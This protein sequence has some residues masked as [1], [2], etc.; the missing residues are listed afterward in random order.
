VNVFDAGWR[1]LRRIWRRDPGRDIDA[2]LRFHFEERIADLVDGGADPDHARAEAGREFGDVA[3]VRKQLV[4]IDGQIAE[5]T[6]RREWWEGVRDEMRYVLRSL[7]RSPGFVAAVT[8]TLA[9]GLGANVAIFSLLDRL[10]LRAQPGIVQPA[11]I[12]RI[13]QYRPP[14][15]GDHPPVSSARPREDVLGIFPYPVY[16]EMRAAIPATVAVTGYAT[17][18][19]AY[20]VGDQAPQIVVTYVLSDYF[21]LLGA[22]PV[23][24]RFFAPEELRI[25][26]PLALVVISER[27]WRSQFGASPAAI[28]QSVEIDGHRHQ[29]IGVAA[30][31]FHGPDNDA[32]DLWVPMNTVMGFET[33]RWKWY[34]EAHTFNTRLLFRAATR[35]QVA[36][37]THDAEMV[38]RH[39]SVLADSLAEARISGLVQSVIPGND[40]SSVDIATRL[41]GVS[42]I[43]LLIACANVGNLLLTRGM[44]RR[45]EIAVRL[46]LGVSRA[47]LVRL[48][49]LEGLALAL[50]GAAI[51]IAV[52]IWGASAL[53]HLLLPGTQWSDG[54]IDSRVIVFTLVLAIVTG[55]AAS[56]FPALQASNPDLVVALKAGA[57]EGI[58]QRSRLRTGLL[59]AQTA[60]SVVLLAGAG[61]FLRSLGSVETVHTGYDG[62]HLIFADVSWNHELSNH[63]AD[64]TAR[65]PDYLAQLRRLPGVETVGY[66]NIAPFRG[67]QFKDFYLP[68]RDS[69]PRVPL[70]TTTPVSADYFRAAGIRVLG[71]R[72]FLASDGPGTPLVIVVSQTFARRFWPG[73]NAVGQCVIIDKRDG[74]CREVI[75]IVSD[76]HMHDIVEDETPLQMYLPKA[77]EDD[78]NS[79]VVIVRA[80]P[81]AI[82]GLIPLIR[83]TTIATYGDWA[84]PRVHAMREYLDAQLR[85]WRLG[86]ILFSVAGF[87]AL[88][89]SLVGI[90]STI[91]YTF[92]QRTHEIGV[93]V[94]LG[95]RAMNVVRLVV[96]DGVR[97]VL[98]GVVIGVM[99]ALVA[100]RLVASMLYQTS[101]RDP[102]V[103]L[104]VSLSLLL[105]AVAAC[106]VPAWRA[107]HVD[108]AIA[109]RAE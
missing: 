3:D 11:D 29:I 39:G 36:A 34:E 6:Q 40:P 86:A 14:R 97:V 5:R 77:Q 13:D 104:I 85:P 106:L 28:G 74:P 48:L 92:G 38:F 90:Y 103:L 108:P 42:F 60:L 88:V 30:A 17:S 75:G 47:R 70:T 83:K 18:T 68:G 8:L 81:E 2:E 100:G 25:E 61:L 54:P 105:V 27:L 96:G 91:S 66:S 109:L 93:R 59:I 58:H 72:G 78:P 80:R 26:T 55:L 57:R 43:I 49:L 102:V 53:R 89:V 56:L 98:V 9:L 7:G 64:V 63:S 10:F 84:L 87:L 46:S 15:P 22:R 21:S 23:L 73:R 76:V 32:V 16:R 50:A 1:R 45:R 65:F 82:A 33:S 20:G 94:A 107:L 51:A 35:T 4:A 31:P 95:A 99:L 101:P 52:S 44:R 24:G 69:L 71:G 19:A 12:H 41:A 79:G 62:D 67:M 37:V